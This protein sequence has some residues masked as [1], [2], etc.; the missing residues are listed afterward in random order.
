MKIRVICWAIIALSG[1][2]STSPAYAT[3]RVLSLVFAVNDVGTYSVSTSQTTTDLSTSESYTSSI[4]CQIEISVTAYN[5][6][7]SYDVLNAQTNGVQTIDGTSE[8]LFN[9]SDTAKQNSGQGLITHPV[10]MQAI[11]PSTD[12]GGYNA[13]TCVEVGPMFSAVAV[14]V[15]DT[16]TQNLTVTPYGE[17]AQTVTKT[18]RLLEW[19][20]LNGYSV[21]RIKVTWTE[22]SHGLNATGVETWGNIDHEEYLWFAYAEKKMVKTSRT[23]TG[24][25]SCKT[26]STSDTKSISISGTS[27]SVLN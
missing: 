2:V 20:T 22:P 18:Y 12:I 17:S 26:S 25:L 1:V 10:D 16:W 9:G 5:G 23:S 15:N 4:N 11:F 8:N 13:G 14:D 7:I 27:E 24:S 6:G 21:A 19:T 3:A